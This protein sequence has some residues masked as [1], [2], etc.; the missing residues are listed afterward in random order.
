MKCPH[1]S[2]TILWRPPTNIDLM[3]PEPDGFAWL[4]EAQICAGCQRPIIQLVRRGPI[5]PQQLP[6]SL[7][8]HQRVQAWPR[9]SR[10]P[11]CPPEVSDPIR[12]DYL[13]A[14]LVLEDSPK[15]SAALSRRCLQ[16]I[17]RDAAGVKH[18]DLATEID[19]V[20]ADGKLPSTIAD[21]LD[22]VRVIGNFAAHPMKS[23]NTGAVLEV[24]PGEAEWTLDVI[25]ALMDVYYVQPAVLAAKK[26]ALNAKLAEAGKQQLP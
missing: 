1:C 16:H 21:S 23:Q 17:L 8:E 11:P 4:V 2:V 20:I 25:E 5:H 9:G 19:Q 3:V 7:S 14:C 18:G 26:A 6:Q 15:A 10:R 13:E 22:A 24:E 12:Q